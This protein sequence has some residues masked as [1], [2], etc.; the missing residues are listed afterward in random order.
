MRTAARRAVLTVV[1]ASIG[2]A[3]TAEAAPKSS[4]NRDV[5]AP[6]TTIT[7]QPADSTTSTSASLS[8]SSNEPGSFE[9]KLDAAAFAPCTS[10]QGYSSL[11]VG[12]HTFQVRAKDQA[13]NVDATP[14]SY[15]WQV[16]APAPP[17]PPP[18]SG[19]V[20]VPASIPSDCSVYVQDKLSV[21]FKGVPDGSTV[22]FPA[23]GCYKTNLRVEIVRKSDLTIRGNGSWIKSDAENTA[24]T[25]Y[26]ADGS[27]KRY[28]VQP[29]V[30]ILH[31]DNVRVD[32]LNVEGNFHLT[33]PR[34]QQ[35][36]NQASTEGEAGATTQANAGY[37]V[38][39]GRGIWIRDLTTR[40][41]FGDGVQVSHSG[42]VD[43]LSPNAHP[44][45]VHIERVTAYKTARMCFAPTQVDG[46]HLIDS[47]ASDCWYGAFDAEA[48]GPGDT[49]RDVHVVGN[50]FRDY[51]MFAVWAP[52]ATGNGGAGNIEVRDNVIA[53]RPDYVCNQMVL[54]GAYPGNPEFFTNVTVDDNTFLERSGIAVQMDHVS[55]GSIQ[56]NQ[57]ANYIEAGC[58]FPAAT[59]FAEVTN[60]TDVAVADNL[61]SALGAGVAPA[62]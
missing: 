36:V 26:N 23:G 39:G 25:T 12:S 27:I 55:L 21:F 5:T 17:P 50:T 16:A 51:G 33:G 49:I 9:C 46:Y 56:H 32:G 54:V 3:G 53:T 14:A 7:A 30:M 2:L 35:R 57:D 1:A 4:K 34:S 24:R 18:P 20:I 47:N 37:G 10:P 42:I 38:F 11:A 44:T 28:A 58:R 60:S 61:P 43:W 22:E 41:V 59:P 6:Q 62:P 52:V 15:T 13:G 40:H 29:T 48:D 19:T 8:F 31:G 45:D